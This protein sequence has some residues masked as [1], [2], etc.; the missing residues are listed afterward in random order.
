MSWNLRDQHMAETLGA[1]SDFLQADPRRAKIVVWA[2]NSHLGDARATEMG[3]RRGELNVGQLVRERYGR[4]AVLV[5]FTTYAG[6]VTAASDW[7]APAE[8]KMVRPALPESYEALFHECGLGNF[9]LDLRTPRRGG[10]ASRAAAARARHRRDLPSG[11]RASKPLFRRPAPAAV[12]CRVPLR[13]H[14]GGGAAGAHSGL[15]TWRAR[16]ARDVPV[17]AVS[18]QPDGHG[19]RPWSQT[20]DHQPRS[21]RIRRTAWCS[22][23]IS[24]CRPG[25]EAWSSSR[26]EVAAAGRARGIAES[27]PSSRRGASPPCCSTCS[28]WL[29]SGATLSRASCDSTSR[30]WRTGWRR[31]PTG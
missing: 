19:G 6:T 11:D 10:A 21:V 27:P 13:P 18:A 2:H 23:A 15:G 9:F 28:R 25:R 26:T 16:V 12:R 24:P 4:A 29:K 1:L 14:A 31:P 3:S 20:P 7:D 17:G 22:T 30:C 8:R 5:G